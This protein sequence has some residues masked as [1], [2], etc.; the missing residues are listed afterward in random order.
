MSAIKINIL[1]DIL[2]EEGYIELYE[3][4]HAI[5]GTDGDS[6]IQKSICEEGMKENLGDATK[7]WLKQKMI[8]LE[9]ILIF[10]RIWGA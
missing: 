7:L 4:C 6:A 8:I 2:Q 1:E 10:E 3:A 5:V 9:N